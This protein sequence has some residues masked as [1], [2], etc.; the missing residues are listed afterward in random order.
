MLGAECCDEGRVALLGRV[1]VWD[2]GV[3]GRRHEDTERQRRKSV[4][5]WGWRARIGWRQVRTKAGWRSKIN[6][7]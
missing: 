5:R 6:A 3:Y 7:I 4:A 1:Q 2:E